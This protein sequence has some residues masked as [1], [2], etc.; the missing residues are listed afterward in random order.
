MQPAESTEETLIL[1]DTAFHL[2]KLHATHATPIY[3]VIGSHTT[4]SRD[5]K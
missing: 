5:R 3:S 4:S 2:C 1:K